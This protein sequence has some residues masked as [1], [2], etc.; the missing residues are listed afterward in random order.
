MDGCYRIWYGVHG[1]R[2]RLWRLGFVFAGVVEVVAE[3]PGTR[4]CLSQC[5]VEMFWLL[6]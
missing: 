5:L 3:V 1:T 4:R 2:R 6:G